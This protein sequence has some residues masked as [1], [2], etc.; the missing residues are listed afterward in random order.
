MEVAN[1]VRAHTRTLWSVYSERSDSLVCRQA[2]LRGDGV[3]FLL[4]R[5]FAPSLSSRLLSADRSRNRPA[6]HHSSRDGVA[7]GA[8][9]NGLGDINKYWQVIFRSY[10]Q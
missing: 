7:K 6:D 4:C 3:G 9:E 1:T 5:T 8:L 10:V 2:F